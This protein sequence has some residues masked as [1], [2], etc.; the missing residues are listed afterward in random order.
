MLHNE[1]VARTLGVGE[2]HVYCR[3]TD[4]LDETAMAD[5]VSLLSSDEHTRYTRFLFARDRREYAAAHA[6]VR[7]SLSRYAEVAPR[8]WSFR[9]EQGGKPSLVADPCV[10]QLSFSLS[11][12]HGLVACAIAAGADVGS[13]VED[14]DRD[15]DDRVPQRFFSARER[16][17]LGR[18]PS[19]ILRAK[20]FFD[21]WTLKEA[22]IKAIGKGLSHPLDTIVFTLDDD[23]GIT[24]TP[25]SEVD[26]ASWSFRLFSPTE[27]HRL[28]VAVATTAGAPRSISLLPAE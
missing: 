17:D 11:H 3:V 27:R 7:T 26:A 20:R 18:C 12:T 6:L 13:D 19:D 5:A 28:A 23:H 1:G 10:P 14:V 15:V 8:S 2:V 16:A 4:A 24:F 9:E 21:L 25:P 22:Y